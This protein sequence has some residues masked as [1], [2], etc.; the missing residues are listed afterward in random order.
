MDEQTAKVKMILA[1]AEGLGSIAKLLG[2]IGMAIAVQISWGLN[3]SI[4]WAAWHGWLG[5][6]YVVYRYFV[7][8]Y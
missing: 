6:F 1:V 7:G 3:H 5:W 8:I 2:L 4:G